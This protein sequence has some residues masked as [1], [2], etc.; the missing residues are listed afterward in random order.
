M[1]RDFMLP[2]GAL[3]V[4]GAERLIPNITKLVNLVRDRKALLISSACQHTVNDP[5]FRTFPPHCVRGT[6][7]AELIPEARIDRMQLVPNDAAFVLPADILQAAQV[8]LEKQV[9]DVFQNPHAG[10]IVELL[11]RNTQFFV[12][13]VV[14]EYCVQLAAKGLLERGRSVALVFDAI[15][16]LK[17]EEGAKTTSELCASGAR[18]ISTV[19]AIAE[20]KSAG[21]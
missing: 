20:V 18:L 1:Q 9:L 15:E 21:A 10:E 2:G 7:G 5:E 8:L 4:P 17:A 19:E 12:F 3:Y 6:P 13:G 14:T 16:T 11:G